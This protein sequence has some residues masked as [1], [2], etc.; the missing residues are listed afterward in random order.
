MCYPYIWAQ[1]QDPQWNGSNPRGHLQR[2]F[3]WTTTTII[4]AI[5]SWP[6]LFSILFLMIDQHCIHV[7]TEQLEKYNLT[8]VM[9]NTF[10]YC[11]PPH[12]YYIDLQH[13]YQL[14]TLFSIRVEDSVDPDQMASGEAIWSGST[15]SR[16]PIQLLHR[17]KSILCYE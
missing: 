9:L 1:P 17:I 10:I 2:W 15:E 7:V 13:S 3:N 12:F 5:S 16:P 6:N 11:T 14:K 4:R 8:L